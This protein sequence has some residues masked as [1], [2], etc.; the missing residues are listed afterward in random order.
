MEEHGWEYE[1]MM[2]FCETHPKVETGLSCGKCG[3]YICPRCLVQTPV[4]VRCSTCAR[5]RKAP[6]YD[7]KS[8][9][10]TLAI[11]AS[12]I[13]GGVT[14][15]IWTVLF[16][17]FG[18]IPFLP[19][20]LAAGVG[21]VVG[22]VVSVTANRKRGVGLALIA[23]MGVIISYAVVVGTSLGRPGVYYSFSFIDI[24]FALM[25]LAGA[26]YVAVSRVR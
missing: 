3:R 8:S 22:E 18:W 20:I 21:Y 5:V 9:Q 25:F 26:V 17:R 11:V 12:I 16:A 15:V 19:W 13:V 23:A 1:G 6:V 24:V 10:Y 14:G 4:G 2:H 7:V